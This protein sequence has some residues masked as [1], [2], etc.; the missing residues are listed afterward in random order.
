[1]SEDP[2]SGISAIEMLKWIGSIA[3]TMIGAYLM[4][5]IRTLFGRIKHLEDEASDQRV[6]NQKFEDYQSW[7]DEKDRE[8]SELLEK[9]SNKIDGMRHSFD[10]RFVDLTKSIHNLEL[11]FEGHRNEKK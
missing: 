6:R 9:I 10:K 1:M 7:K 11:K 4:Y 3:G 5:A 8:F 2:G